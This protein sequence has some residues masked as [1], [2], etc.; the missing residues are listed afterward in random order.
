MAKLI[1]LILF[2][3]RTC[4]VKNHVNALLHEHVVVGNEP[5]LILASTHGKWVLWPQKEKK[6]AW[7]LII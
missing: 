6:Y 4:K 1:L 5:F 2:A 3:K 7:V